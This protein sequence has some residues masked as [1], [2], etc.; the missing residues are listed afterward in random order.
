MTP[1]SKFDMTTASSSAVNVSRLPV[2]RPVPVPATPLCIGE[3]PA[4]IEL[5]DSAAGNPSRGH[6][7]LHKVGAMIAGTGGASILVPARSL[8]ETVMQL[9][10]IEAV[11][12]YFCAEGIDCSFGN[13]GLFDKWHGLELSSALAANGP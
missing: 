2:W 5:S 10:A 1:M 12:K 8:H 9:G 3:P 13:P 7:E 6:K 11:G 4:C